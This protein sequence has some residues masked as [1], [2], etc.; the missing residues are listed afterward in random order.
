MHTRSIVE[1]RVNGQRFLVGPRS[2]FPLK[3]PYRRT[4]SLSDRTLELIVRDAKLAH[5]R[6][7][8]GA[9]AN[10]DVR[11]WLMKEIGRGQIV[12][13]EV[14]QNIPHAE[15]RHESKVAQAA[16]RHNFEKR[17]VARHRSS[18]TDV[19]CCPKAARF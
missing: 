19:V 10:E 14:H 16:A 11:S 6:A 3:R 2:A 9:H 17:A 18:A 13:I 8:V 5:F 15:R 7:H 1:V 12:I 4:H